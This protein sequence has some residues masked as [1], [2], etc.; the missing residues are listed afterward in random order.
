[1][2][3]KLWD[4]ITLHFQNA[5]I[6]TWKW[7]SDFFVHII[8][9]VIIY[10]FWYLSSPM[11]IKEA[12]DDNLLVKSF[13]TMSMEKKSTVVLGTNEALFERWN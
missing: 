7:I 4:E 13:K 12:S 10:P 2:P 5:A 1:M 9:D 6:E 11:L 8:M 3:S